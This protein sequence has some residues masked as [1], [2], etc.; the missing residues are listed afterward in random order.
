MTTTRL[1]AKIDH[2]SCTIASK[3]RYIQ[4]RS[5]QQ[6]RASASARSSARATGGSSRQ[7]RPAEL[8]DG[9]ARARAATAGVVR[10]RGRRE[11]GARRARARSARRSSAARR[12]RPASAPPAAGSAASARLGSMQREPAARLEHAARLGEHARAVGHVVQQI[13]DQHRVERSVGERQPRGVGARRCARRW[14]GAAKRALAAEKSTPKRSRAAPRAGD[15]GWRP[16]RSRSRAAARRR[17]RASRRAAP[18][19]LRRSRAPRSASGSDRV[20]ARLVRAL[21]LVELV[22]GTRREPYLAKHRNVHGST[23]LSALRSAGRFC[24]ID[25]GFV[26]KWEKICDCIRR[27]R[28]AHRRRGARS[29]RSSSP[30]TTRPPHRA[31]LDRVLRVSRRRA[32]RAGRSWSSTTARSDHTALIVQRYIAAHG[33]ARVRFMRCREPRQ[34][35]GAARRRRRHAAARACW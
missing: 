22:A 9:A 27:A 3:T 23:S 1:P 8:A 15:A 17:S 11:A 13:A 6:R 29:S 16:R 12:A 25:L 2:A 18:L 28:S 19:R 21:Q 34:G 32:I 14:R 20:G 5:R 4:A 26:G 7:R 24:R 30:R 35:R 33:A 10:L 31:A